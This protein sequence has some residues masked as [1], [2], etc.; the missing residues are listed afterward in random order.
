MGFQECHI[1]F[2]EKFGNIVACQAVNFI[3]QIY[4]SG[5]AVNI[6]LSILVS[7]LSHNLDTVTVTVVNEVYTKFLK[8]SV[9]ATHFLMSL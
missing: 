6:C 2:A 7:S 4:G 9:N 8:D 3:V 5:A 1:H